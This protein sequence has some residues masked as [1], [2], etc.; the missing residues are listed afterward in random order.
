MSN[1]FIHLH[2]HSEYSISDSL[3]RIEELIDHVSKNKSPAVAI[4]DNNNIFSLIK[5]YK[6]AIRKGV[7]PIIGI[8]INLEDKLDTEDFSKIVLLCKNLKG[9]QNLS[10]LI[11][12]SYINLNEGEVFKVSR[13]NLAQKSEGLIALSGGI[14]GDLAKAIKLERNDLIEDSINYWRKNF[15][16][17]FYIEITRTGRNFEEDFISAAI[18][19][20]QKHN[21]PLVASNDVRFI[22]EHD[23]Q[24][25]E[26]RVC[27]NDGSYLKDQK[28][29]SIYNKSQFLKTSEEML[30][31]FSDIPSAIKNSYEIARRCNIQLPLGDINMPIF[32][33]EN[34]ID[35]NEYFTSLVMHSLEKKNTRKKYQ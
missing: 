1:S 31:L 15:P 26:V 17:S 22:N 21:I 33:L 18:E 4:T 35:E 3:I 27:I 12:E 6:T 10:S 28:R 2:L 30:E 23:Y 16:K 14:H 11:T 25:H 34:N 13:E 19:L 7:K 9:F 29:V 8:E 24:A 5:F 32:P 20:S